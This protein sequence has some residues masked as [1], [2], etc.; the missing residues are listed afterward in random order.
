MDEKSALEH[1]GLNSNEAA[2]YLT[3]LK[4]G[5]SG[6]GKISAKSK[7]HRRTVYD[8]LESLAQKGLVGSVMLGSRT[9]FE[10]SDPHKIEDFILEKRSLL[11][12]VMP[13]LK[14]MSASEKQT[15]ITVLRGK[16]GVKSVLQDSLKVGRTMHIFGGQMQIVD[17]LGSYHENYAKRLSEKNIKRKGVFLDTEGVR[18]K[19]AK[20]GVEAKFIDPSNPSDLSEPSGPSD[21]S[22]SS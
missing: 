11:S 8:T 21:P 12:E 14:K 5:P 7:V 2:V 1:I 18:D 19:T 10:A 17:A 9:V 3:L 13:R 20:W 16:E 15:Q 6:A 22:L 4:L